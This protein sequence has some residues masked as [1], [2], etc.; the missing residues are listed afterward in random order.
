MRYSLVIDGWTDRQ[1]YSE[2]LGYIE[3]IRSNFTHLVQ[4]PK[5]QIFPYFNSW[6]T[7]LQF[8]F[9]TGSQNTFVLFNRKELIC[10]TVDTFGI[11]FCVL[12][13]QV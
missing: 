1:T 2:I 9:K 10:V 13:T 4:N 8:L 7:I 12:N 5:N 6:K 3:V 11:E